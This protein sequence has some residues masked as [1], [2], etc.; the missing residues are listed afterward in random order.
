VLY[1]LELRKRPM[2]FCFG[3]KYE[4]LADF[5]SAEIHGSRKTARAPDCSSGGYFDQSFLLPE[6]LRDKANGDDAEEYIRKRRHHRGD[7]GI[8]K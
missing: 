2:A 5:A 3:G 1:P 4:R 7:R 6:D 8:L